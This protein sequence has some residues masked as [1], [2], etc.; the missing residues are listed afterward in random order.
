[1]NKAPNFR[2]YLAF[3]L[4]ALLSLAVRVQS[5]PTPEA[6]KIVAHPTEVAQLGGAAVSTY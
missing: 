6:A 3:V 4:L 1:M 2:Y 5:V